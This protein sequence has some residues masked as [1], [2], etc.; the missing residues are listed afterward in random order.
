M[1]T[2][3][4]NAGGGAK[5]NYS[6]VIAA[7]YAALPSAPPENTIGLITTIPIGS[8]GVIP[9]NE[10]ITGM[11]EGDVILRQFAPSNTRI[12]ALKK[13]RL[14]L[15]LSGA[16]QMQSG[17]L[18]PIE[19][20]LF[21]DSVWKR[22]YI[23]FYKNS[24]TLPIVGGFASAGASTFTQES[25]NLKL[26]MNNTGGWV[27]GT[28]MVELTDINTIWFYGGSSADVTAYF[29]VSK[30]TTDNTYG[31]QVVLPKLGNGWVAMDV[32]G[33]TGTWYIRFGRGDVAMSTTLRCYEWFGLQ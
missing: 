29:N 32:S 25:D 22:I 4:V 20:Y 3:I 30:S 5:L 28:T 11:Q 1:A 27:R 8:G 19:S 10:A 21:Q 16:Y 2:G 15:Y 23:L 14:D 6:C 13:G 12:N 18:N 33:L 7:S 17:T 26:Y 31:A 24:Q 9:T